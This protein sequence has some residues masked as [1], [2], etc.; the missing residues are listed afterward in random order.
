MKAKVYAL[1]PLQRIE[2]WM[3]PKVLE[4]KKGESW[5]LRDDDG[6]MLDASWILACSAASHAVSRDRE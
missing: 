2:Y 5:E 4:K 1:G 6:S 3:G